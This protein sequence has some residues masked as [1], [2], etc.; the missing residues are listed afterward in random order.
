VSKV[1]AILSTMRTVSNLFT[2]Y[3][4]AYFSTFYVLLIKQYCKENS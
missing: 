2:K 1:Q 4:K 3:L